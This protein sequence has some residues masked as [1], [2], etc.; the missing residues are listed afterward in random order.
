MLWHLLVYDVPITLVEAM[1]RE[2][3]FHI[4]RWFSLPRSLSFAALYKEE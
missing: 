4:H 3:S 2:I 1:E